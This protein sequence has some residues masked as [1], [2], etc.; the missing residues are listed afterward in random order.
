VPA[1]SAAVDELRA[2]WRPFADRARALAERHFD[3]SSFRAGYGALYE[4]G[5]VS[6]VEN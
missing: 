4:A 1:L 6:L 3:L 2:A 5:T